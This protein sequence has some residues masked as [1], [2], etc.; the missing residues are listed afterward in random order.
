MGQSGCKSRY[1]YRSSFAGNVIVTE[2]LVNGSVELKHGLEGRYITDADGV[3]NA[4]EVAAG[5]DP[6]D[7]GSVPAAATP[8]TPVPTLPLFGFGILVSLYGVFGLRKLRH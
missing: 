5:S 2:V 6:T 3:S 1:R 8:A 7:S 4:D